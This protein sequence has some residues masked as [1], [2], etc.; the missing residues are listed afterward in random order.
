MKNVKKLFTL[1]ILLIS[2]IVLFNHHFFS[3][4]LTERY[5]VDY[6]NEEDNRDLQ[7][8]DDD[9]IE[10]DNVDDDDL[11]D[12]DVNDITAEEERKDEFLMLKIIFF[13]VFAVLILLA[14][15]FW[16]YL[17]SGSE[18]DRGMWR[19]DQSLEDKY[20]IIG[21]NLLEDYDQN[22]NSIINDEY[23]KAK[24]EQFARRDYEFHEKIN[25]FLDSLSDPN[26]PDLNS[27]NKKNFYFRLLKFISPEYSDRRGF[28]SFFEKKN[29]RLE[30]GHS[31]INNEKNKLRQMTEDGGFLF[32]KMSDYFDGILLN[33]NDLLDSFIAELTYILR[34]NSYLNFDDRFRFQK[35]ELKIDDYLKCYIRCYSHEDTDQIK[36]ELESIDKNE[37]NPQ[38]L[39]ENTYGKKIAN[40]I[41][42][43]I[44]FLFCRCFMNIVMQKKYSLE[45]LNLLPAYLQEKANNIAVDENNIDNKD[46]DNDVL[47][48]LNSYSFKLVPR[49]DSSIYGSRAIQKENLLGKE[50]DLCYKIKI[51]K[52]VILNHL[53]SIIT[54]INDFI[55]KK[56]NFVQNNL[57]DKLKDKDD[58]N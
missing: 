19:F 15:S 2:S 17:L 54:F 53:I 22:Q 38:L 35:G 29:G 21:S 31:L 39:F 34:V 24:E 8:N 12:D 40:D 18:K 50:N 4:R 48:Q 25:S 49:M 32:K 56:G 9:K 11:Q 42:K 14:I 57:D 28:P 6:Q 52:A 47:D 1:F 26:N 46:V 43:L 30:F 41:T 58:K 51:S 33:N 20:K 27:N 37:R 5:F 45:K 36:K 44:C 13:L 3:E 23:L 7:E 55:S 16:I 10:N